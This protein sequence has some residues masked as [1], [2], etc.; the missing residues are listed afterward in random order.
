LSQH[1]TLLKAYGIVGSKRDGLSMVYSI[2]D[3]RV[4]AV[5]SVLKSKYCSA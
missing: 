5:I 2:H 1:L 4:R 3:N